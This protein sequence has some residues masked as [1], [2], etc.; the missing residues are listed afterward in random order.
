MLI[1]D[2]K[3]LEK[4]SRIQDFIWIGE[5]S[6]G[7]HLSEFD[8]QTL[9]ENDFRIIQ[10]DKLICFGLAGHGMSFYFGMDGVFNLPQRKIEISY[11]EGNNEYQLTGNPIAKYN[12]IITYKK[13]ESVFI[14]GLKG[15][16]T[17]NH[18][19]EYNVGYKTHIAFEDVKFNFKPICVIPLNQ[20][21][22]FNIR[23][24]ASRDMDGK[25]MI[26]RNGIAYECI[27][28]PI[29]MGVGGEL[30]WIVR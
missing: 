6:D 16:N 10:R 9:Q 20:P 28:A 25:L 4:V 26:K 17:S 7:T 1:N 13:A 21:V 8:V 29:R 22:Y 15:F 19:L 24:V 11:V 18:I 27:N 3:R 2:Y 14:P 30:N 12:D 5:Y 23:L